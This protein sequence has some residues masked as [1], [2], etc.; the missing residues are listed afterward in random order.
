MLKGFFYGIDGGIGSAL[1]IL[2]LGKRIAV[3][4]Y[5]FKIIFHAVGDVFVCSPAC[6][7]GYVGG[8]R[9]RKIAAPGGEC[10]AL[11]LGYGRGCEFAFLD[12]LRVDLTS[13]VGVKADGIKVISVNV[14]RVDRGASVGIGNEQVEDVVALG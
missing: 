9:R 6:L 2:G 10:V 8:D 1:K 4:I 13:A 12:V 7:D 14:D 11:S 3:L 5:S